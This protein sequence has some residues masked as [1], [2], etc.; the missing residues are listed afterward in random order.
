MEE[1]LEGHEA[2]GEPVGEAGSSEEEAMPKKLKTVDHALAC[3]LCPCL[4]QAT[5]IMSG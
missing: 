3:M 2:L 1:A 4:I 5:A